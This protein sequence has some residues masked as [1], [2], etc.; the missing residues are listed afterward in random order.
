MGFRYRQSI[1]VGKFFRINISTRG[2]GYSVGIPGMRYTH[3][4][5]GSRYTTYSIPGTGISYR[6]SHGRNNTNNYIQPTTDGV[7]SRAEIES[8]DINNFRSAEETELL[9]AL[10]RAADSNTSSIALILFGVFLI[11]FS[12]ISIYFFIAS[13]AG[14]VLGIS[15][16]IFT[17]LKLKVALHYELDEANEQ[18]NNERISKWQTFFSCKAVWQVNSIGLNRSAKVNGGASFSE[19]RSRISLIRKLP[20]YIKTNQPFIYFKLKSEIIILL[21]DKMLIRKKG[22]FGA[23]NY[24][25]ISITAFEQQFVEEGVVPRDAFESGKTWKYVN[26]NGTPDR[27]FKNNYL[28]PVC[29]YGYIT[30]KSEN[31]L[32]I[33]LSCSNHENIKGFK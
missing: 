11:F 7:V 6:Q 29:L 2:I 25:D 32:N 3:S 20:F 24:D 16:K 28:I 21:P 9:K 1:S 27:R 22:K 30:L 17:H 31:G 18:L 5:N 15:L 13:C 14:L 8:A 26:K 12:P 23:V 4:A 10:D 19:T 33:E